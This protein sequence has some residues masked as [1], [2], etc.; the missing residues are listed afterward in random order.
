M[1]AALGL[2][3]YGTNMY[4]DYRPLQPY[5]ISRSK[6]KVTWVFWCYLCA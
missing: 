5:W 6:V 1:N 2:M 4:L 3:I